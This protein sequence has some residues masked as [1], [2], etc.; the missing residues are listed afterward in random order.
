MDLTLILAPYDL[1]RQDVGSGRGPQAYLDAG[2]VRAL[3]AHGHDVE[4]VKARRSGPFRSELEAV[5]DINQAIA[6]L[7]A[8][9][10]RA[11]RFPLVI[12]GNCN[13]T[14]GVR[15]GLLHASSRRSTDE[16]ALMWFDAHG[17]F[18]TPETSHTGYLDGMPLAMLTG[19]A[20]PDLWSFLGG[21]PI[22]ER[23]VLHVGSRDLDPLEA[24]R[25]H[26]SATLVVHGAA[27][28]A[29]GI[30]SALQPALDE[31]AARASGATGARPGL[32]L[33]VD[34]DV[35]DPAAAPSVAFPSPAGLT[36]AELLGGIDMAAAR[37]AVKALSLTSF[38]PGGADDATTSASGLAVMQIAASVA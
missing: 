24:A 32:H 14:L 12:A 8:A 30:G 13:A 5:L 25:L 21:A 19:H 10:V 26:S 16:L 7:V 6:E 34:I 1:G 4:V 35:L 18:N 29:H 38:A 36:L 37:F 15:T 28:R 23:L 9:A 17:D 31:L 11:D 33:H 27:V 20:Y 2:A 3:Q 22:E